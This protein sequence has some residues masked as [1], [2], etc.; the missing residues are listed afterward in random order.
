MRLGNCSRV[1]AFQCRAGEN[2]QTEKAQYSGC[3]VFPKQFIWCVLLLTLSVPALLLGAETDD[4]LATFYDQGATGTIL[5]D[6][7][8]QGVAVL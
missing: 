6:L 7:T 3:F 1:G 2:R 5:R 4:R 8:A